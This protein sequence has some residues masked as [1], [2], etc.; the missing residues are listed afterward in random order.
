M[1]ADFMK[2]EIA[3]GKE[4]AIMAL[5]LQYSRPALADLF[6]KMAQTELVHF[7]ALHEHT[8]KMIEE[9]QAKGKK[10]PEKM[11]DKWNKKHTE[12]IIC[13]EEVQTYLNMYK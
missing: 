2:D 11:M 5:E 3:G 10:V 1:M 8:I 6:Y 12:M 13:K 7:D 4:Y 9:Y